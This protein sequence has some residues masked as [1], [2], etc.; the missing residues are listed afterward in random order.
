MIAGE[1][2][3]F[4]G[5]GD[6]K[7]HKGAPEIQLLGLV[8]LSLVLRWA[9]QPFVASGSFM[10][11][12]VTPINSLLCQAGAGWNHFFVHH[13]PLYLGV[14]RQRLQGKVM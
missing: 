8:T 2:R 4:G 12:K 10:L 1:K 14:N 11:P 5:P 13:C 7:L 9:F 6:S 3:C